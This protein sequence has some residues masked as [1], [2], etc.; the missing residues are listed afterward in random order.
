MLGG[1]FALDEDRAIGAISELAKAMSAASG[2]MSTTLW[3]DSDA[4]PRDVKEI[5]VRAA[6]RLRM[7]TVF[8]ANQRVPVPPGQTTIARPALDCGR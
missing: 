3:V 8:V 6:E 4:T 1:E 2:A 7:P 5:V